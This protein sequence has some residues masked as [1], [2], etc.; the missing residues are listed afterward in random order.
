MYWKTADL[1][2]SKA[3]ILTFS[4]AIALEV[5]GY[6]KVDDEA[7]RPRSTDYRRL[8]KNAILGARPPIR[9]AKTTKKLNE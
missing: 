5:Q 7:Q 6:S 8:T 2:K 1:Y 3:V 4:A 9:A